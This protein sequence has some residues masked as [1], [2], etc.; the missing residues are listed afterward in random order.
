M[1]N[2]F[3]VT[4][5][6]GRGPE[7]SFD[8]RFPNMQAAKAFV[9]EKILEDAALNVKAIYRIYDFD[10]VVGE[11]DASK[12]DV[13]QLAPKREESAS[14][15]QGKGSTASFRPTPLNTAPRPPGTPQKW[16]KD[17]EEDG[18]ESKK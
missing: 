4:K 9:D 17:E 8:A 5:Q 6:Y 13:S 3:K 14:G 18:D 11:F 7:T 2:S 10:D 1:R 15:S 12:M 16:M